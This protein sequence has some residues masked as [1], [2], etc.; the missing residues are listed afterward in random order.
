[1]KEEPLQKSI[2][3]FNVD[4]TPNQLGYICNQVQVTL[5]IGGKQ[6][7]Q[8]LLVT[9]LGNHD[10]ILGHDWL[11]YNNP[12]IDWK[13]GRIRL[14]DTSDQ[15]W[16]PWE[17]LQDAVIQA[18]QLAKN[19]DAPTCLQ[20]ST[21]ETVSQ[22]NQVNKNYV[23]V[24]IFGEVFIWTLPI[25][26][27]TSKAI[28]TLWINFYS[29]KAHQLAQEAGKNKEEVRLPGYLEP[30]A[31]TFDK[32]K[33]EWILESHLYDHAIDLKEDFIPRDCKIYSLSLMEEKEMN[34]FIDKNLWKDYI[35]P[36]KSPIASL[37]FF[38]EKKD[39]KLRPCQDYWY[40]NSRT[41]KH[42]YP[43]LL[44]LEIVDRV[45]RWTHFTKL[46]LCSSYNNVCIKE[47][48]QWKA[49]FKTKWGLFEPTV[50]F[51][52]LCN[53]LATFQ[54][55]MNNI[56]H[57]YV[58]EGWLHIYMDDLLLCRQSNNDMQQKT[59]KVV[60]WL[61]ENN[62]FLK[63]E[64]CKFDIPRIKF[65]G[66]IISHD[67][68]DMDPVKVQG[69][70]DWPTPETVKQVRGFLGFGNF[71]SQFIDHYFNIAWCLIELTKKNTQFNWLK[72]CEDV[73]QE[74]KQRFTTAPVLITLDLDKPFV[75]ECD[76]SLAATAAVLQ[77]QDANGDW[78]PVA[79]L[80]QTF[81]PA[82]RN[83]EIYDRELLA[84]M[85]ALGQWRHYLEGT[86]NQVQVLTGYKNLNY[87][88]SPQRLNCR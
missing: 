28:A 64:K 62:L 29:N 35:Q 65:L 48:D 55:M 42:A 26:T 47:G 85:Q 2:P 63:L 74:L 71:Y 81:N 11:Q 84:I 38:I 77:Q 19:S 27:T 16:F 1:M 34:E 43:L 66:M 76:A 31:A 25:T 22:D 72:Q 13:L 23:L 73:F 52:G 40:L 18:M 45:K 17:T 60:Q 56:F 46:N 75:L 6:T 8:T 3:V 69:V 44:I 14:T 70:L 86:G 32:G 51:F 15:N 12:Q 30:Y 61:Q 82:E 78:H 41:V 50:M 49:V 21:I 37:F 10:I 67:Q 36:L 88:Q 39:R 24:Y 83:Y 53:S 54:S 33:A 87:F 80:S 5:I 57:N 7:N 79:Y 59:L 4:G 9:H 58:D 20:V 68:V